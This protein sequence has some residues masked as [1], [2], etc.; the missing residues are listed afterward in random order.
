MMDLSVKKK[1]VALDVAAINRH[2]NDLLD[3]RRHA[4]VE[5]GCHPFMD[6]RCARCHRPRREHYGLLR[7]WL[8]R[9]KRRR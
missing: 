3:P 2:G 1:L 7:R 8:Q 6:T 4:Y 5:G 9:L